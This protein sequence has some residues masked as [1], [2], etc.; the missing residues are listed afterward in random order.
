MSSP[1]TPVVR[2]GYTPDAWKPR[3]VL[4]LE[5]DDV[6]LGDILVDAIGGPFAVQ[7]IVRRGFEPRHE[8]AAF[9]PR[10]D[11]AQPLLTD[12]RRIVKRPAGLL[13]VARDIESFG[14][15]AGH[16]TRVRSHNPVQRGCYVLV[17]G[18]RTECSCGWP[19]D[20]PAI[21][22]SRR[23]ARR[24]WLTHKADTITQQAS[25]HLGLL[26]V[27]A[28]E[29]E[30]DLP[31]IPWLFTK[32]NGLAAASLNRVPL[33]EARTIAQAWAQAFGVD[34]DEH[35]TAHRDDIVLSVELPARVEPGRTNGKTAVI[36]GYYPADQTARGAR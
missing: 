35:P 31:P 9:Q 20:T 25:E 6:R 21:H 12:R 17:D 27:R 7:E 3:A 30:H 1:T 13:R 19:G 5:P 4:L 10:T 36:H 32:H 26:H 33:P 11:Y 23:H 16:H 15:L 29:D 8:F 34:V 24:A 18:W 2:S 14:P 28:A 22:A